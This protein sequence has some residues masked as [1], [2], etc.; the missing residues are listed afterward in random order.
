MSSKAY[1]NAH[2]RTHDPKNVLKCPAS[3]FSYVN[4]FLLIRIVYLLIIFLL[5]YPKVAYRKDQ[6]NRH[7]EA[8]HPALIE[9]PIYICPTCP[10]V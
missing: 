5:C 4:E 3:T 1:F 7:A 6:M 10:K 2:I 9:V 8:H